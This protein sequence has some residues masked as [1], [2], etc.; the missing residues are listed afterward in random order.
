MIQL[1]ARPAVKKVDRGINIPRQVK[2]VLRPNPAVSRRLVQVNQ[3]VDVIVRRKPREL[4]VRNRPA[5]VRPRVPA[6]PAMPAGQVSR[7]RAVA[8]ARRVSKLRKSPRVSYTSS[9]MTPQDRRAIS[10]L[11]NIGKGKVLAIMGNGPSLSEAEIERLSTHPLVHIMSINRPDPRVWPS[12]YWLFCDHTQLKRHQDL[13]ESYRGIIFN[14]TAIKQRRKNSIQIRNLGQ[15]GFSKDLLTG[16][17]IGRSSCFA[18]MQVALWMGYDHIYLFGVDMCS[19][20]IGGQERTHYYGV[21][22]DVKPKNRIARFDLEAKHYDAA[23]EI[24]TDQDRKR[25]T[26]CSG[27]LRYKFANRFNRI[28]HKTAVDK[29]LN[30]LRVNHDEVAS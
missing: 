24:L 10:A 14:T 28:D 19:V 4:Q 3:G 6:V 25:F 27:Y 18:A 9:E 29:I 17:H 20:R 8:N 13:W 5:V 26:F 16:F 30:S 22:P 15:T 2:T 7:T 21:N 11:K 23:A 1:K 12:K